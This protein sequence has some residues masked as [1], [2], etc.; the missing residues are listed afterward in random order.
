MK[1]KLRYAFDNTMSRGTGALIGWLGLVSLAV[2]C[3]A[4]LV[5]IVLHIAPEGED[6][7][8]FIEGLWLSLMRTLDSG[9][10]G[11]DAGWGFRIVMLLVTLGGIFIVSTLIGVLSSGIEAKIDELRKG[12]SFVIEENHTLILGWSTKVFTIISELTIA[13]ENQKRPRVVVL[14][15]KDKVEMEDEIRDKVGNLRNTK[16]ICRKGN[17]N[18][19]V[20][21]G[22]SNPHQAKS[23][24]ILAP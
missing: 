8:N 14:A 17:P 9:T 3:F 18:D 13:N 7:P 15:D 1:Q 4:S 19:L 24:I 11:G 20:D 2:I 10:M 23:I 5:L 12:R 6:Q 16:V 21:L 22:I